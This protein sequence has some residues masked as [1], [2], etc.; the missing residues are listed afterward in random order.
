M[1]AARPSPGRGPGGPGL[2]PLM[3]AS[4]GRRSNV[5]RLRRE[6]RR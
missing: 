2:K 1:K 6:V 3:F 5:R 4:P